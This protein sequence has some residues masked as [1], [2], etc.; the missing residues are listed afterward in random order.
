MP[1]DIFDLRNFRIKEFP[2]A[3][4]RVSAAQ[5]YLNERCNNVDIEH[6][7]RAANPVKLYC[8]HL[9]EPARNSHGELELWVTD[10]DKVYDWKR[11]PAP[12]RSR[13]RVP[14]GAVLCIDTQHV[15]DFHE[16]LHH[17]YMFIQ[18]VTLFGN[19]RKA[20]EEGRYMP[21]YGTHF[22][23]IGALSYSDIGNSWTLGVYGKGFREMA[24]A[25]E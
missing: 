12:M 2:G 9:E 6:M 5:K 22:I 1:A 23:E 24:V 15:L 4:E 21:G 13:D 3:Y 17:P 11:N 20:G 8:R 18:P 10:A 7:E 14:R 16:I 19:V 25:E